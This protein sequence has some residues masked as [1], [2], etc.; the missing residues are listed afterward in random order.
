VISVPGGSCTGVF[1]AI[2][3]ARLG[4]K[5]VLIKAVIVESK[6]GRG[7]INAKMFVDATGDSDLYYRLGLKTYIREHLQPPTTCAGLSGW[8][9]S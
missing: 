9:Q 1:A 4:A 5:V 2:R 6:S 7:A 8:D 3:A